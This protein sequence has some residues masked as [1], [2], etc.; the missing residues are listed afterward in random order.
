MQTA[1]V[2]AS[3]ARVHGE[4]D[5]LVIDSGIPYTIFRPTSF[6]QNYVHFFGGMIRQGAL[7][8]AQGDGKISLIDV[9]D[10]AEAAANILENPASHAGKIYNLTGAEA[11]GNADVAAIIGRVLGRKVDYVAV[12]D[13]AAA[14]AMRGM[15]MNDW[16]IDVLTSLNHL[17]IAGHA[18]GISPDTPALLGHAPIAFNQFA[19]ENAA[20]WR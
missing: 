8:V 19:D 11:L 14:E 9:R 1:K 10:I 6:M 17:I 2:P 12:S 13:S 15:G 20:A 18:A 7:H 5:Q 3:I 16:T 4:A